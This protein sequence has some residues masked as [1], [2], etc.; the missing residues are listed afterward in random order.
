MRQA[1]PAFSEP[2]I[3]TRLGRW[4]RAPCR[5]ERRIISGIESTV[6]TDTL[7]P[8]PK[9]DEVSPDNLLH[10]AAAIPHARRLRKLYDPTPSFN[11]AEHRQLGDAVSAFGLE[12]VYYTQRYEQPLELAPDLKLTYGQIVALGGDLYGV[13]DKPVSSGKDEKDRRARFEAAFN[14][15]V[16]CDRKELA[17]ILEI[18]D[19][20]EKA[21]EQ[22]ILEGKSADEAYA[23]GPDFDRQYMDATGFVGLGPCTKA[24]I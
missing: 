18:M 6:M 19:N 22:G 5:T 1:P 10:L 12:N 8:K 20:E 15:L 21:V 9:T 24:A 16:H 11:S 23:S 13:P 14:T 2:Q 3:P 4:T 7:T 17:K